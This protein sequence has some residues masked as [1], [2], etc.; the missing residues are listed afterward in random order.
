LLDLEALSTNLVSAKLNMD[1]SELSHCMKYDVDGLEIGWFGE[2]YE[3]T[4]ATAMASTKI[5]FASS[6]TPVIE[7]ISPTRAM[8]G[9]LLDIHGH[10][11]AAG[12]AVTDT[13]W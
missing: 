10:N 9:Q 5:T 7:Y 4:G 3:Y 13:N 6:S 12:A 8:P 1:C 2:G 11:F